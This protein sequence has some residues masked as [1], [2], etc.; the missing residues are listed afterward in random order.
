M[1][2]RQSSRSQAKIKMCLQGSSGSGKTMSSLLIAYGIT[3]DWNKIAVVDTENKSADL[4]SHLGSYQVI[5]F[6]PPFTP[7]RYCEAID[8]CLQNKIEVIIIDSISHCWEYLLDYHG[9][10]AGNSFTNWAKINPM[11]KQFTDKLLQC[12]THVIATMRSKQDYVLNQK[13]GKF[14]PEKV[15]LKGIFRDGIEYEFTIVF[16]IDSNHFAVASKDRTQVFVNQPL[17]KITAETGKK[18][19]EWCNSGKEPTKKSNPENLED[20]LKTKISTCK[21]VEDLLALFK[22]QPFTV[23][24]QYSGLFT[25][26]RN[27]FVV[28]APNQ[29]QHISQHLKPATNGIIRN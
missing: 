8:I 24:Q 9:N 23:Q 28:T 6:E 14:V 18:I 1:Q 16:D 10:L 17:F 5:S 15:G 13:D 11:Q 2:L 26:K 21:T 7:Q 27:E 4:F 12:D 20:I 25:Q 19:L 3:N 22:A 29:S